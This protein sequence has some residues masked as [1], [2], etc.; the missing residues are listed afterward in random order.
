[1]ENIALE[2][3]KGNCTGHDAK[4]IDEDVESSSALRDA[5]AMDTD[6]NSGNAVE[7]QKNVHFDDHSVGETIADIVNELK[8]SGVVMD[9]D[10]TMTS[11]PPCSTEVKLTDVSQHNGS[12]NTDHA[13]EE[14][15]PLEPASSAGTVPLSDPVLSEEGKNTNKDATQQQEMPDEQEQLSVEAPA[16][17]SPVE[18]SVLEATSEAEPDESQGK[19]VH[20]P[21][22]STLKETG[23]QSDEASDS[24]DDKEGDRRLSPRT[25]SSVKPSSKAGSSRRQTK[26]RSHSILKV[27]M[28]G[29]LHKNRA[30]PR[31]SKRAAAAGG[32]GPK[33]TKQTQDLEGGGSSD[34]DALVEPGKQSRTT[35]AVAS[36]K[37]GETKVPEDVDGPEGKADKAT[38]KRLSLTRTTLRS[39]GDEGGESENESLV[40]IAKRS[41]KMATEEVAD[42]GK[43]N[44][45]QNKTAKKLKHRAKAASK[46]GAKHRGGADEQSWSSA[47]SEGGSSMSDVCDWN[48][49]EFVESDRYL[50]DVIGRSLGAINGRFLTIELPDTVRQHRA[51]HAPRARRSRPVVFGGC[52]PHQVYIDA[53]GVKVPLICWSQFAHIT[54]KVLLTD[55]FED[56]VRQQS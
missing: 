17:A 40:E 31:S 12:G 11:S 33:D 43:N 54:P 42:G 21:D 38:R 46:T 3:D 14:Q 24:D 41:R 53:M 25:K 16:G 18:E 37:K 47:K 30:G 2:E 55:I 51:W 28:A 48:F 9:V 23:T 7:T 49:E 1:M 8:S 45:P 10:I 20:E 26:R 35:R 52:D 22:G 27:S 13:H 36:G 19:D 56:V 44:T 32:P 29:M 4:V 34:G 50:R 39:T 15:S 6:S 5:V